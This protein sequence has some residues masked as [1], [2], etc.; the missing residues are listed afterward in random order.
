M[1]VFFLSIRIFYVIKKIEVNIIVSYKCKF[2]IN[3]LQ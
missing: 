3:V 1:F 2:S